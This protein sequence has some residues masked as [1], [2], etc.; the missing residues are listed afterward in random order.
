MYVSRGR[1]LVDPGERLYIAPLGDDDD[2]V[3]PKSTVSVSEHL[4]DREHH[5]GACHLP[6]LHLDDP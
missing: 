3:V 2:L 1:D 5:V 4:R 6:G